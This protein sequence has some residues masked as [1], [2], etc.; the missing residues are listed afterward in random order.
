MKAVKIRD[1][2]TGRLVPLLLNKAQIEVAAQLDRMRANR[3]P[4]RLILLKARQWGG[5]T[6]ILA[7]MTWLQLIHHR[8]WHSVICAHVKD[9]ARNIRGMFSTI[10][11][12][13]PS[14]LVDPD[15]QQKAFSLSPFEG[16]QNIRVING[17]NCRVAI[18]SA[19]N[20]DSVRGLDIAMAH[21]SEV[22][23]WKASAHKDPADF[24]RAVCSSVP[25][26]PDTFVAIE[27]TANGVGNYF[28]NEWI[29]AS[30]NKS[31]KLAVFIPWYRIEIYRR[32]L[33]PRLSHIRKFVDSLN[34]YEINLWKNFGCTLEQINWY[35]HKLREYPSQELMQAEFPTTPLEAFV[36]A[37]S[38]VFNH[39][40]IEA[41]RQNCSTPAKGEVAPDA[42]RF[43]PDPSGCLSLWQKPLPGHRYVVTVDVGGRSSKS[44][45]SVI[46]VLDS[47]DDASGKP[48][49]VAQW[50]GHIYHDILAYRAMN[51]AAFYNNALLVVE[52]NTLE[53]ADEETTSSTVL[54][55]LSD[56]YYNLYR[57]NGEY[58][59]KGVGFHT[60]R[61]TKALI[62]DTLAA[63]LRD[64]AY[65]ERDSNACN[66][67]A[68]YC[69]LPNGSFRAR[70][71]KHDDILMTRAIS[72]YILASHPNISPDTDYG[73][74]Y[75]R[76]SWL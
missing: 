63:A 53:T 37:E 27:S 11:N 69:R 35:R 29:R 68:T 32:P 64:S 12:S 8:N 17:R 50:R 61:H 70:L 75:Y 24:F 6:L 57:R 47:R 51:I 41:L 28:H 18:A 34:E 58:G 25:L 44:D 49:V 74:P 16:A 40:H 72:L 60:N 46:A 71:G 36:S 52:S 13:Y 42:T 19:E 54:E 14:V 38:N 3:R 15:V 56:K 10:L 23:F 48:A 30:E 45:W 55:L 43:I 33:K 31:D 67:M 76:T 21:L 65:I 22:A 73:S 39:S 5:S 59:H 26:E 4:I 62:I 2:R 9:S 66:E 20:Q 7:Y 1:K